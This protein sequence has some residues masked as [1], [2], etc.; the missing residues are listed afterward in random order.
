M[1]AMIGSSN[2][3]ARVR[4]VTA[5]LLA[6]AALS[7]GAC[8]K[9]DGEA[10]AEAA[11]AAQ[12][13]M[14]GRE[15]IAIAERRRVEDGPP[16]S[17]QLAADKQATV[18]AQ[19]SGAVL[20][21]TVE[22]GQ[23]VSA[24]TLLARLDDAGIQQSYLSA[25]SSVTTAQSASALST[26]ELQR[27]EKLLAAGAVAERDLEASRQ[28]NAGAQAALADARARLSLA[29][30]QLSYTRVTAPFSGVVSE[31]QANAGDVV[32]PGTAMFTVVEPSS[33]RLEAS[34]PAEQ[35]ASVKV[36][37]PVTFTVSG[38]GDKKFTGR[39][40]RVN[41][42]AD[43]TTRQVRI[44]ASIPNDGATLVGGLF[45]EGRVASESREGIVLPM[46]AVDQRG[47]APFVMRLKNGR[48][49]KVTVTLGLQDASTES[50]EIR[51]GLAVGDTVLVGAA[52]GISAGTAVRIGTVT[53]QRA[54]TT[55]A[56]PAGA[57]A[58]ATTR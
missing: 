55:G 30:K 16:I 54:S 6:A 52:Q 49:E 28:S 3:R 18:R 42:V 21:T 45:A 7:S 9:G 24:G 23:R 50:V 34:V 46:T 20:Q 41:P 15:S 4:T 11:A 39:I 2:Q 1:R 32:S 25:R 29:E 36:G 22:Q 19:V 40:T 44:Y 37:D 14:V 51:G 38:Y 35:L 57:R 33:M 5:S 10:N 58:A 31:R 53:D 26:R 48:S 8:R 47:T 17:G 27:A 13:T 56:G 43:A 12:P